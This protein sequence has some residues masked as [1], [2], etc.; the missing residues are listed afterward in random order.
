MES[1]KAL[2]RYGVPDEPANFQLYKLISQDILAGS[3]DAGPPLL[4][5]MLLRL[6]AKGGAAGGLPPNP[7]AL[8]EDTSPQATEFH[9][10]LLAAH[11]QTVRGSLKGQPKA[12]DL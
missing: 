4:R 5:Q 1:C 10:T 3:D 7:K 8:A 2:V 6:L 12:A 11:L 9:K